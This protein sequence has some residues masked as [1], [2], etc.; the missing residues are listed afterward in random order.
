MEITFADGKKDKILLAKSTNGGVNV[1]CLF[2]GALVKDHDSEV[3][4]DGCASSGET[5]VEIHSIYV[6]CGF[7]DLLLTKTDT[8]ILKQDE[9][10]IPDHVKNDKADMDFLEIPADAPQA[11]VRPWP[12][13]QLPK[14]ASLETRI[15]YDD[16]LRSATGG[17]TQ[18]KQ[19]ISRA[20]EHAKTR[21][22]MLP[23]K[24]ELSVVG[25]M[26]YKS[27]GSN[28]P[29][30]ANS[31]WIQQLRDQSADKVVSHFARG[32]AAGIA[33]VGA[34]CG[35]YYG[36]NINEHINWPGRA[37]WVTGRTY[38]HELGHNLGMHHDFA[39][40]HGGNNSPGS[41]SPCDGEGLMSYGSC[42]PSCRDS[43]MPDRWS[44]CSVR[45]FEQTF[46]DSTH[47]CLAE[48]QG[49]GPPQDNGCT[50]NG[51]TQRGYGEC[52]QTARCGAW[53]YV[54][55]ENSCSY[56]YRSYIGSPYRWT[57]E[58]CPSSRVARLQTDDAK[59]DELVEPPCPHA[60][61][62]SSLTISSVIVVL[63]SV[64]AALSL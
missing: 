8:Y 11:N 42:K 37:E 45:D 21:L 27:S 13:T 34:V 15:K 57:C 49:D 12:H 7:V 22:H 1:P 24:V 16:G 35:G 38:A 54:D 63:L 51:H 52:Q 48:G 29:W 10:H 62:A 44:S 31:Y 4:V 60:Y 36:V 23:I 43:Q 6:P 47:R 46:R 2:S 32:G 50:C 41:G 40:K 9:D 61:S 5:I 33:Y 18:A 3:D 26:Q 28:G 59:T 14:V 17:D 39:S 19:F 53:C 55:N 25:S 64:L 58:A 20:V 56:S 30:R